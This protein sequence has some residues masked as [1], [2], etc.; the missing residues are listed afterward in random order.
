M[1]VKGVAYH[2]YFA[3]KSELLGIVFRY[4][5]FGITNQDFMMAL[6]NWTTARKDQ[7]PDLLFLG[8]SLTFQDDSDEYI[9][10]L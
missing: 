3:V 8:N 9:H 10:F 4:H 7:A 1:P 2:Q 6:A 5:F